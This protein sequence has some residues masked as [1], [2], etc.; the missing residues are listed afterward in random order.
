MSDM[1]SPVAAR[2]VTLLESL[3]QGAAGPKADHFGTCFKL[4]P[5]FV[6]TVD[7]I[8]PIGLPVTRKTAHALCGMASP[9]MHGHK[10]QTRL[11]PDVRDTW[12]IPASR[13]SLDGS[14]WPRFLKKLMTRVTKDLAMPEG[15]SLRAELHNLLVYERGQFFSLH[16][17]SE[18]LDGMIGTLVLTLPSEFEGGEF[19]LR[20][21][22][23]RMVAKGSSDKVEVVAFYADCHHEVTPVQEG[24]RVVLTF[25]LVMDADAT[26]KTG[27]ADAVPAD[28]LAD[29]AET[30][31]QFWQTRPVPRWHHDERDPPERLILLLDHQYT[32]A[33]LD[34]SRLKGADARMATALKAV[35]RQLDT[36]IF[37]TLADVHQIWSAEEPYRRRY[38]E[39][40]DDEA[41]VVRIGRD[42]YVLQDLIDD[43]VVLKHWLDADGRRMDFAD[44]H[45][46]D[47]ETCMTTGHEELVP[48]S[49]EYEGYMGNY[50]NTL[51]RW[52]HRAA[53]VMWPRSRG[54][55][56]RARQDP[57][58]AM[59][60]ILAGFQEGDAAQVAARLQDLK[61]EW[62]SAVRFA[63]TC[64]LPEATLP[65][66]VASEDADTA[67]WLLDH[68]QLVW[69]PANVA[70][71]VVALHQTHGTDWLKARLQHW[72][73]EG[74]TGSESRQG[75]MSD[76]LPAWLEVFR[77]ASGEGAEAARSL[78]LKRAWQD[79]WEQV[80]LSRDAHG[81]QALI[82]SLLPL[83]NPLA[84]LL[85]L[86]FAE[87]LL[88]DVGSFIDD[89]LD[90]N[91][92]IDLP[93]G[94]LAVSIRLWMNRQELVVSTEDDPVTGKG[95][96]G[97]RTGR[98]KRASLQEDREAARWM[99]QAIGLINAH[100]S[101]GGALAHLKP[102]HQQVVA[103]LNARLAQPE[104]APDDWSIPF[105]GTPQGELGSKLM[106]FLNDP[107]GKR[108]VWPL[109]KER[110]MAIHRFIDRHELPITHV[111]E[112]TGSPHKLILE[113]QPGLHAREADQR[114]RWEQ[115]FRNLSRLA[116]IFDA[117]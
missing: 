17:D 81:G 47:A 90:D 54:F 10:D 93:V 3:T 25:N 57:V 20:H 112:R 5:D 70:P 106:A 41:E 22:N 12:E 46:T 26:P 32:E 13:L 108:L 14:A 52:Y 50:G 80:L 103:R 82:E 71:W 56:L 75:W 27:S 16:Q 97:R 79:V 66:A 51:D 74:H 68:F 7:G 28:T 91:L 29:L 73:Q 2:I 35:A 111:T 18:K 65:V 42:R 45:A 31:R 61:T 39:D 62:R 110:R 59:Q 100:P 15:V 89:L 77:E 24:F 115:D 116:G 8:G 55:L 11:D 69:L 67:A 98:K 76:V 87:G 44:S 38:W 101:S 104:R 30:I 109:A 34:W 33:G 72:Y 43:D 99:D 107:A 37:L 49:A 102:L 48:F 6:L 117:A 63:G 114:W 53:M 21:G 113:K 94:V 85:Q 1:K 83:A 19:V 23:K 84:R 86:G 60:Q 96:S 4:K 58:W 78:L 88:T 95:A 105:P 64:R 40:E 9:A 92:P 36:D